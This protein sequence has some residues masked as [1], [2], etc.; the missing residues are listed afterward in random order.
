M[1]PRHQHTEIR[2]AYNTGRIILRVQ[3]ASYNGRPDPSVQT[4]HGKTAN[5]I[6]EKLGNELLERQYANE[7]AQ[8]AGCVL[9]VQRRLQAS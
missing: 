2:H 1:T 4:R 6:I 9:W 3:P 8:R 5:V 7:H